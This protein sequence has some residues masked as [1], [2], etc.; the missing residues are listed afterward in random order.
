MFFLSAELVYSFVYIF[1]LTL[2][3]VVLVLYI[4]RVF[5]FDILDI[6]QICFSNGK[7]RGLLEGRG[8]NLGLTVPENDLFH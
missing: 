4:P 7:G 2:H 6:P 8:L 5:S 1:V 3:S